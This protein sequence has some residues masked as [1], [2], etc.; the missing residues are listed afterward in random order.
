MTWHWFQDPVLQNRKNYMS[1]LIVKNRD[2]MVY[3]VNIFGVYIGLCSQNRKV[4]IVKKII[5]SHTGFHEFCVRR[6]GKITS[7]C[8]RMILGHLK[9]TFV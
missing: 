1:A 8:L 7:R 6:V 4:Y 2:F 9:Y 5:D 3:I